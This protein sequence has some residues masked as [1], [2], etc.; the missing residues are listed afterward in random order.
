MT[1]GFLNLNRF[2]HGKTIKQDSKQKAKW[3]NVQKVRG[4]QKR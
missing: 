1:K 3:Q 2:K 4:K